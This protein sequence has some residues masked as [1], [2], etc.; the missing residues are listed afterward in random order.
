MKVREGVIGLCSCDYPL[1]LHPS[2]RVLQPSTV[3]IVT[4]GHS[5]PHR[6]SFTCHI[7]PCIPLHRTQQRHLASPKLISSGP[8]AP[9]QYPHYTS[10]ST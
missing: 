5:P 10:H 2:C 8:Q 7:A 3:I 9:I 4:G 1:E 6:Q